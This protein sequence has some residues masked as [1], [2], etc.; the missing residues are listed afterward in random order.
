MFCASSSRASRWWIE[1][2]K[3][4]KGK[5]NTVCFCTSGNGGNKMMR[6]K[7]DF[8]IHGA[9]VYLLFIALSSI[10]IWM[11]SVPRSTNKSNTRSKKGRKPCSYSD[12]FNARGVFPLKRNSAVW[13]SVEK[14]QST[15]VVNNPWQTGC[16]RKISLCLSEAGYAFRI[17]NVLISTTQLALLWAVIGKGQHLVGSVTW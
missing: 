11:C 12:R 10:T 17:R 2:Y 1:W 6:Q 3:A 7:C 14:W 4:K 5:Q 13:K 16:G 15:K 9:E 8:P